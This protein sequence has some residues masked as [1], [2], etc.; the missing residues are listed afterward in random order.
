MC[1]ASLRHTRSMRVGSRAK[2][3]QS[4]GS[5]R[6]IWIILWIIL[7]LG[8]HLLRI[9]DEV[10][11]DVAAIKLHAFNNFELGL[12]RL[13]FLDGDHT[14]CPLSASPERASGRSRDRRWPRSCR[15][16]R[17]PRWSRLILERLRM[18]A[19]T[20]FTAISMPRLISIGLMLAA[21]ALAP[22]LTI[23]WASSVAVVVPSPASSLVLSAT[24]FT[25]CAPK[26]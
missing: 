10:W 21:T 4:Y 17:S 24:C 15:S 7:K 2:G 18:F 11:A 9:G 23:A 14:L 6:T 25:S 1:G 13:R 20:A 3:E 26:A 8:H 12:E 19:T 16:A 22:S 5:F